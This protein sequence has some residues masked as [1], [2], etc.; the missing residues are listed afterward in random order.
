MTEFFKKKFV[1]SKLDLQVQPRSD[2]IYFL[3]KL[4]EAVYGAHPPSTGGGAMWSMGAFLFL[5]AIMCII[6]IPDAPKK[7]ICSWPETSKVK[8]DIWNLFA[9]KNRVEWQSYEQSFQGGNW[10][11][12]QTGPSW[13]PGLIGPL[14]YY[15]PRAKN[16]AILVWHCN[17]YGIEK[18][19]LD[20]RWSMFQ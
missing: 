15:V 10:H 7:K 11:R 5:W 17:A 16:I 3:R 14:A 20:Y 4:T 13:K 12:A 2:K 9:P 6:P 18:V 1:M 19:S 8:F